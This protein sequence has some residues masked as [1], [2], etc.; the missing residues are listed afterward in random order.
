MGS[1]AACLFAQDVNVRLAGIVGLPV[2]IIIYNK[3]PCIPYMGQAQAGPMGLARAQT[4]GS[5]PVLVMVKVL[6]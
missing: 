1:N 2:D 5:M 6:I 3:I 4:M